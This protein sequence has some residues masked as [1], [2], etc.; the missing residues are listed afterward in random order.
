MIGITMVCLLGWG[1][2]VGDR[3]SYGP[4]NVKS[5]YAETV[6]KLHKGSVG[7]RRTH[8]VLFLYTVQRLVFQKQDV[9]KTG[10]F[11]TNTVVLISP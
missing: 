11:K 1:W 4:H 6:Q 8:F 10:T 9:Y 7:E 5:W 2:V 3:E